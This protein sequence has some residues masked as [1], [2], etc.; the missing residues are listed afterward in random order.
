MTT[1]VRDEKAVE[2]L[3]LLQAMS[4]ELER[5]MHAI[6]MDALP[7][8][9]E[10]IGNQQSL[11][12]RLSDIARDLRAP[13]AADL[14]P[15]LARLDTEVRT[16]IWA[17]GKKLQILNQRYSALLQHSSRSV[18]LMISLFSSFQGQYQEVTGARGKQTWSCQI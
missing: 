8:L 5:A 4:C 17:A 16:Q 2:Y 3:E 13:L 12:A 7:D 6:A 11:S 15:P 14:V 1:G 18:A 9:E 10:S